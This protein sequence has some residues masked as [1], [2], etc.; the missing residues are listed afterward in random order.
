[1]EHALKT[2]RPPWRWPWGRGAAVCCALLGCGAASLAADA[3]I[4]TSKDFPIAIGRRLTYDFVSA[5]GKQ[6]GQFESVLYGKVTLGTVTLYREA[7]VAGGNRLPDNNVVK[8]ER[9]VAFYPFAG[10]ENPFLRIPFPL[11][12]GMTYEYALPN[13]KARA[14]V[15]GPVAVTVPAGKFTCLLCVEEREAEGERWEQR[16]WIAPGTGTVKMIVRVGQDFTLS[17]TSVKDPKRR[18]L[19]AGSEVVSTFESDT[20]LVPE[21]FPKALWQGGAGNRRSVSTCAIEPRDAADGSA[22]C[23]RWAYQLEATWASAS[24]MPSGSWEKPVDLS[25]YEAISFSVKAL[26]ER[27]CRFLF[28]TAGPG[29]PARVFPSVPVRVT[30]Q[31]Q[32]ITIDLKTHPELKGADLTK[33]YLLGF[34][35]FSQESAG[36]VVWIDELVLHRRKTGRF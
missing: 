11:K 29:E 4:V 1:M 32:R 27:P 13:G 21:I 30:R 34:S 10:G 33:V 28:G 18:T 25:A 14:R 26:A 8:A 19:Q 23:L 22:L 15:E 24:F 2:R 3:L 5:D 9:A 36:N 31:W 35:D 6:R 20:P 12:P 16:Y 17:L 7:A